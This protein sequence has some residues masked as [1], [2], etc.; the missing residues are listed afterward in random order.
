MGGA[1][2]DNT[3]ALAFSGEVGPKTETELFNGSSWTEVNDRNDA[4]YD[5]GG[6]GTTSAAVAFGGAPGTAFAK[7][8]EWT[9]PTNTTVTFTVS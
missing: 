2:A 3:V 4:T 1:G 5:P 8:E 9:A 6:C 7:T